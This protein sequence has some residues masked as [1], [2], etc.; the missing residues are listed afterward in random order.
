MRPPFAN[1]RSRALISASILAATLLVAP[2]TRA[3]DLPDIKARGVLRHLG[4]PYANFVT[5]SN[6]GFDVELVRLFAEHLGVRYEYVATT[7][8]DAVGDL[9]GQIVEPN[10]VNVTLRGTCPV[11][12]DLIAN[13]LTIL[14]WR[15]KVVQFSKP[16]FPTQVWLIA[17][18]DA[19]LTPIKPSGDLAAD[20]AATKALLRDHSVLCKANS[21]LDPTLHG[22]AETGGKVQLFDGGLNELAPA[23]IQGVAE[24]TIL[25]VPDV[26]IALEKWPGKV[27]VIGPISKPQEMACGFA[28]TA[29][30]LREAFEKFLE[31]CQRDGTYDR[32]IRKYYP[33]IRDYFSE[34]FRT[35]P[36]TAKP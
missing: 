30:L 3:A 26:L 9:T 35:L 16:Y 33:R 13:G 17:R 1:A 18:A 29:P 10:G 22:L 6:D 19:S 11:R 28:P 12:G 32:L 20:I 8:T 36:V 27:K 21:C 4:V 2:L 5:G 34:F 14:P 24:L 25:D 31:Q 23:V 7:W 15:E